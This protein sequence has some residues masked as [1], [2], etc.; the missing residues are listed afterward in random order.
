[1]KTAIVSSKQLA[2]C[3]CWSAKRFVD[4][5]EDCNRVMRCKLLE[6]IKGQKRVLRERI[7]RAE[8]QI[9]RWTTMLDKLVN[10]S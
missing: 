8:A 2:D 4:S 10:L 5:C 7:K 9:K 6:G 1:M 3:K